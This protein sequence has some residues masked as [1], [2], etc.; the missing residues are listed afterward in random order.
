MLCLSRT[1][2]VVRERGIAYTIP[3]ELGSSADD[4]IRLGDRRTRCEDAVLSLSREWIEAQDTVCFFEAIDIVI[5]LE[6]IGMLD[7]VYVLLKLSVL[8]DGMD[9]M[10]DL[11]I[12]SLCD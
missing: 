12:V 3:H 7:D 9:R 2:T 5:G 4:H 1:G 11:H 8:A 6:Q 10:K